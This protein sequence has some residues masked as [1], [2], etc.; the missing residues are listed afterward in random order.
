MVAP[1]RLITNPPG[2]FSFIMSHIVSLKFFFCILF[3]LVFYPYLKTSAFAS[4]NRFRKLSFSYGPKDY[5]SDL[6]QKY[7]VIDD[8]SGINS[9]RFTVTFGVSHGSVISALLFI[10]HI[11]IIKMVFINPVTLHNKI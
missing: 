5:L 9:D 1:H 6:K 3:Y 8:I 11:N 7:L 4:H 2:S 10:I